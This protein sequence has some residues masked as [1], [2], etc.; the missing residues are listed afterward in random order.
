MILSANFCWCQHKF[1]EK[2]FFSTDYEKYM[3]NAGVTIFYVNKVKPFIFKMGGH[4]NSI[5]S[6]VVIWYITQLLKF[7][8]DFQKIFNRT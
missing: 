3:R 5:T 7:F 2:F 4:C 8:L 6:L 1:I